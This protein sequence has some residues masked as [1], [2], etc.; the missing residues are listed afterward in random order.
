MTV[1]ESVNDV[2]AR[3]KLATGHDGLADQRLDHQQEAEAP[4][5]P[6]PDGPQ[7]GSSFATAAEH[8]PPQTDSETEVGSAGQHNSDAEPV[9]KP[10][11][12]GAEVRK[13]Q[14]GRDGKHFGVKVVDR[15]SMSGRMQGV[16]KNQ[17]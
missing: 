17:R 11:L 9:A 12:R 6:D 5:Q 1:L 13:T 8:E 4:D 16:G 14:H 15:E 3:T 7:T 10:S 2:K